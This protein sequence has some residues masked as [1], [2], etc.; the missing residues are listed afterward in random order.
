MSAASRRQRALRRDATAGDEERARVPRLRGGRHEAAL[1][2]PQAGEPL[3]LT[4]DLLERLDAVAQAGCI[5]VTSRVRELRESS[6]ETRQR[7]RGSLELVG[8]QCPRREL[9]PAAR[10]NRPL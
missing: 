7:K 9:R 2:R 4:A 1:D 10:A 8:S 3:E 5:L 6:A